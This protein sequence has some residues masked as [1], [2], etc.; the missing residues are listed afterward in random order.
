M[1]KRARIDVSKLSPE[2]REEYEKRRKAA[3]APKPAYLVY[4]L[5]EDGTVDIVLATRK[6]EEAMIRLTEDRS[7]AYQTIMIK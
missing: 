1:A 6:A 3:T 2:E 4:R 5:A 7:L